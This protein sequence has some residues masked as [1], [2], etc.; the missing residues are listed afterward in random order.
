MRRC[1][2]LA[3]RWSSFTVAVIAAVCACSARPRSTFTE[4]RR[5]AQEN[6]GHGPSLLGNTMGGGAPHV[7]DATQEPATCAEA[8]ANRSYVGCDFWPTVTAN[9]VWSIFDY[10]VVVANAGRNPV[11][12]KVTGPNGVT[13]SVTVPPNQLAKMYLPWVPAL[14]GDDSDVCGNSPSLAHSVL[15][16]ASA[17]H[18]TS[19]APVTVYQFN[20]L[21]YKGTGGPPGKSWAACPGSQV[22]TDDVPDG[23]TPQPNGCFSFTNDA[24]L[25]MPTSA[26]TGN[27][28]VTGLKGPSGAYIAITA[29]QATTHVKV[30]LAAKAKILGTEAAGPIAASMGGDTLDFMLGAGDV[31]E[32]AGQTD[33]DVDL[34]GSLVTAD[35]PV[36]VLA[37]IPCAENPDGV[38]ACDHLEETVFP[39]ET[40]GKHYVVTVPTGPNGIPVG[41]TVRFVGNTDG[42]ALTYAPAA[43]PGCPLSLAAGE[44]AECSM[45]VKQDFE[46]TG[47]HEFAI[48]GIGLAA[49]LVDPAGDPQKGDPAL[50]HFAAVEQFRT[51]YVFLAP[52][53]YDVSFADVVGPTGVDVELDGMPIA[54]VAAAPTPVGAYA[55]SRVRLGPGVGGAHVLVA[56]APVALQVMGYGA[57]TSY[58]FP[59]G[60]DL[61]A[62]AAAPK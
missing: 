36:Q 19:S 41:H 5:G 21:E 7:V 2:P 42:T 38:L 50:T 46:V 52:D 32:I 55:V 58:Q 35:K 40:L 1:A 25:L 56:S 47:T 15:A 16:P 60:L 44:V 28:R 29:T 17:Y 8:D 57:Y 30:R 59:G 20:A 54:M 49:S 62:I 23:G 9:P 33:D 27:Y 31:A 14:K 3:V 45:I 18:L 43:P 26:M 48:A 12:V 6:M 51:K 61:K 34:A 24:S 10:A 53:D 37:G 39:A 22:C 13:E 4:A 11:D